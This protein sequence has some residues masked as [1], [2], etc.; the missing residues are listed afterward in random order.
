MGYLGIFLMTFV[1]STFVPIPAEVT[2]IPAGFLVHKGEMSFIGVWIAST[3][4]TLGGSLF[5]YWIAYHYGRLL[6][7]RYGQYFFMNEEKLQKIEVFFQK[8][9]A[10]STFTGRFLP[11]VKHVISFPAGL[12]KMDMKTFCIYTTLGGSLWC[13]VLIMVGYMIGHNEELIVK[14]LKQINFVIIVSISFL[15]AFYIWRQTRKAS[16]E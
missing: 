4:G 13:L 3:L 9:G 1:E 10:F 16:K 6:F 8:H 14:Y 2:L 5:N 15:I 11:G 12:A 7:I